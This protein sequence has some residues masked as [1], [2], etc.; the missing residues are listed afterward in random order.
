MSYDD[1]PRD[2]VRFPGNKTEMYPDY[3]VGWWMVT[4][5][6]TSRRLVEAAKVRCGD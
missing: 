3:I 1:Y 2:E 6:S 4:N 5:P